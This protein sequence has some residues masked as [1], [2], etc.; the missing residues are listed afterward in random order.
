VFAQTTYVDAAISSD[1]WSC[2]P[3]GL[4]EVG[5]VSSFVK[6][7]WTVF[8]MWGVENCHFLYLRPVA[9]MLVLTTVQAVI[10]FSWTNYIFVLCPNYYWSDKILQLVIQWR[11]RWHIIHVLKPHKHYVI[12]NSVYTNQLDKTKSSKY[13]ISFILRLLRRHVD[14]IFRN[15]KLHRSQ[16]YVHVT[17]PKSCCVIGLDSEHR[18]I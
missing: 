6:I 18:F 8:E 4:R 15:T 7:G 5:L 10:P 17:L 2:M 9:Y 1:M 16:A 12:S 3:G 11:A 13:L 14:D